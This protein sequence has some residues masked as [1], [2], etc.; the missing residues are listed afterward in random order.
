[1]RRLN[2]RQAVTRRE[3]INRRVARLKYKY[4]EENYKPVPQPKTSYH[5]DM[6]IVFPTH[7]GIVAAKKLVNSL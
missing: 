5:M 1:M 7:M 4:E 3:R 2:S 6:N